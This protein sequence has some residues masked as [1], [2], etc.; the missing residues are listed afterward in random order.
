MDANPVTEDGGQAMSGGTGASATPIVE[1]NAV[2]VCNAAGLWKANNHLATLGELRSGL[3]ISLRELESERKQAELI[4]KA[5]MVAR[6]TRAA[7]DAF[8]VMTAALVKVV[9]PKQ[10]AQSDMVSRVYGAASP[11]ADALGNVTAGNQVDW[12]DTAATSVRKGAP[13]MTDNKGYELLV[14]SAAI[15]VEV[16]NAAMHQNQSKVIR[17]SALYIVDL[18][19]SAAQLAKWGKTA[20]FLQIAKG[21]YEY[22]DK[23]GKAFDGLI[24]DDLATAEQFNA[25]KRTLLRCGRELSKKIA[26]L[27]TFIASCQ[28]ELDAAQPVPVAPLGQRPVS[29]S[30]ARPRRNV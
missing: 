1:P 25:S 18:N 14:R 11:W 4:N 5:L 22:N 7:A 23:I 15:K 17:S 6:F 20:A 26:E 19:A 28:Q 21:A 24:E 8:V 16:V 30:A 13:L 3:D 9:M 2:R 12:V 29:P 27:E 10:A